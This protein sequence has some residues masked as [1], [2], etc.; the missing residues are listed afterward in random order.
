MSSHGQKLFYE[1]FDALPFGPN[2]EEASAGTAVWTKTPP[3]GWVIDDSQMPGFGTPEYA[4]NDG[5]REWAG[6]SFA[7]ARW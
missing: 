6:W 4:A 7:D 2:V 1:G 5:R 3:T